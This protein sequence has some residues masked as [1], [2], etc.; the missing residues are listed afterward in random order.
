MAISVDEIK[1]AV[2]R[3]T[4]SDTKEIV[5]KVSS[6]VKTNS[7]RPDQCFFCKSTEHRVKKCPKIPEKNFWR[8]VIKPKLHFLTHYYTQLTKMYGPLVL[9]STLDFERKHQVFKQKANIMK[10]FVNPAKSFMCRE[11]MSLALGLVDQRNKQTPNTVEPNGACLFLS[12]L[13]KDNNSRIDVQT[14]KEY[15]LSST[16]NPHKVTKKLLFRVK[17][18]FSK[19]QIWFY[20]TDYY[21]DP[22]GSKDI[23]VRGIP[24]ILDENSNP[25]ENEK[26]EVLFAQK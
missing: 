26:F 10:N 18:N 4:D 14:R 7:S 2:K 16:S 24:F 9:W 3:V 12:C 6:M 21:K 13:Y 8:Y 23:F 15:K 19:F 5:A 17:Q 20:P 1:R 25:K 11:Q 22:N